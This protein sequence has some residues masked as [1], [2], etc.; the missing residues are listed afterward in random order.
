MTPDEMTPLQ[1]GL[2]R[3]LRKYV[4]QPFSVREGFNLAWTGECPGPA[5]V[6]KAI[7]EAATDAFDEGYD[8]ARRETKASLSQ[9]IEALK[10]KMGL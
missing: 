5:E 10:E 8:Q 4:K 3:E 9:G 1:R 6:A 2:V 7:D